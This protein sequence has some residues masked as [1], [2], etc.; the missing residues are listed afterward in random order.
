MYTIRKYNITKEW[1][2]ENYSNLKKSTWDCA[3]EIGC[4]QKLITIRMAEYG[5]KARKENVKGSRMRKDHR[6][7]IS[8]AMTDNPKNWMNG[9]T[10]AKHPNWKGGTRT[11]R[12]IKLSEV[13]LS[14]NECGKKNCNLDVHHIDQDRSNNAIENLQVLCVSCHRKL[15]YRLRS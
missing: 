8:K 3:K 11:Y 12:R 13:P 1:L 9:K 7:K 14:C 6:E 5:I 2:I 15:H 4:N 10:L